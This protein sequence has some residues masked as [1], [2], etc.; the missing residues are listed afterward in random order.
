MRIGAVR[1]IAAATAVWLALNLLRLEAPLAGRMGVALGEWRVPVAVNTAGEFAGTGGRRAGGLLLFVIVQC[2]CLVAGLS[3]GRFI[4]L[5]RGRPAGLLILLPAGWGM[6]AMEVYAMSLLGLVRTPVLVTLVPLQAIPAI[7]WYSTSGREREGAGMPFGPFEKTLMAILAGFLVYLALLAQAPETNTDVLTQ[8]YATPLNIL[9]LGKQVELPF[10]IFDDFPP[11]FEMLLLPLMGI[12]GEEGARWLN[13]ALTLFMA[14]NV[15]LGV[16][17]LTGRKWGLAAAL[18]IITNPF[19]AQWTVTAKNDIL[20]AALGVTLLRMVMRGEFAPLSGAVFMGVVAGL[21]FFAK[22]NVAAAAAAL[23]WVH[24]VQRRG[25]KHAAVFAAGVAA[26]AGPLMVR[27]ALFTGD[28]VY[29]FASR[30]IPGPYSTPVMR[31]K[32]REHLALSKFR[33]ATGIN[34]SPD[35][36]FMRWLVFVPLLLFPAAW[37]SGAKSAAFFLLVGGAFWALGPPQVRYGVVMFPAGAILAATAMRGLGKAGAML[38]TGALALQAVSAL[39][40]PHPGRLLRAAAGIE[41]GEG[42]RQRVLTTF[43][44]AAKEIRGLGGRK[45]ISLGENRTA[46]MN[47]RVD[48]GAFA[49]A[50]FPAFPVLKASHN[51]VEVWKGFKR[52]GWDHF[53]YNSMTAFFWR[54]QLGDDPWTPR[55]LALWADF[56]RRHA[57]PVWESPF[58]DPDMGHFY[59]FRMVASARKTSQAVLPG[60]EGWIFGMEEDI[61]NGRGKDLLGKMRVLREAAGDFGVTDYAEWDIFRNMY[62]RGRQFAMLERAVDRGFRI[63]DVYAA[64]ARLS[65][66]MR[67][68]LLAEKFVGMARELD[69]MVPVD[70]LVRELYSIRQ[71]QLSG[72]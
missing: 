7:F 24:G 3:A 66:E 17:S 16:A 30:Y 52:M 70:G 6:L 64:L 26:V 48:Y 31:E 47:A 43:Y 60:V 50:A 40:E 65:M 15:Y 45:F 44:L 25:W 29:P 34:D 9:M 72:K 51:S 18:L 2:G 27:N 35:E 33:A 68:P 20:V 57:E 41:S 62:S 28:P 12:A 61:R 63:R 36:S 54:R 21:L 71:R 49:G 11:L 13:P 37:R 53:I 5:A 42:Y 55:E 58:E 4:R 14:A 8:H 19:I 39:F 56:W 59:L 38:L 67:N 69:P 10:G 46:G 22:Y 1:L 23:L 32:H